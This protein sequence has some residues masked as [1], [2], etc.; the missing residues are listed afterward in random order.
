MAERL[1]TLP[2]GIDQQPPEV[3]ALY[4][5]VNDVRAIGDLVARLRRPAGAGARAVGR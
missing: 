4:G 1:A 5:C 2:V 3:G